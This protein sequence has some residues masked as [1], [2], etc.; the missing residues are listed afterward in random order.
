MGGRAHSPPTHGNAVERRSLLGLPIDSTQGENRAGT[1]GWAKTLQTTRQEDRESCCSARQMQP[2]ERK[3]KREG[4]KETERP[5]TW[6]QDHYSA[7]KNNQSKKSM[8][9][10]RTHS[11]KTT[12]TDNE[13]WKHLKCH[14]TAA[15]QTQS[16]STAGHWYS[17]HP[18][19]ACWGAELVSLLFP[20]LHSSLDQCCIT[21]VITMRK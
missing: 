21:Q 6:G 18:H 10:H 4:P 5:K 17:I 8:F 9:A 3:H 7:F 20:V 15:R 13:T 19:T 16:E 11:H 1:E 12:K 2:T 14:L